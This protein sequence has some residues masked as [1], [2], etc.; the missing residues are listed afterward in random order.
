MEELV[1]VIHDEVKKIAENG[2][3]AEDFNNSHSNMKS[4]F[5]QNLKENSYWNGALWN[6]YFNGINTHTP[7][8]KTFEKTDAKAIQD[9][10]KEILKQ[11]N[12]I[13]VVML[14]E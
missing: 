12:T 6:F 1:A 9:F 11:G 7:W 8:Q 10:A 3:L 5:E 2:P 13:E 14:P 4:Q